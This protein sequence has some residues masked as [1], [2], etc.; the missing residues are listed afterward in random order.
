VAI[1]NTAVGH[2][3]PIASQPSNLLPILLL[4]FQEHPL[5]L[6]ILPNLDHDVGGVV[7][8]TSD[9][10][11]LDCVG[12]IP[13]GVFLG[14]TVLDWDL[15]LFVVLVHWQQVDSTLRQFVKQGGGRPTA[16]R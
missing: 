1:E 5:V 9:V 3:A 8:L 6:Q 12:D 4:V 11:G 14:F 10:E 13:D 2:F 15:C 7:D 16:L